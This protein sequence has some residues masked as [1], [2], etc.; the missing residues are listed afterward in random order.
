MTTINPGPRFF[1]RRKDSETGDVV[2]PGLAFVPDITKALT[3]LAQM[4]RREDWGD[5]HSVLYNYINYTVYE[6]VA[7]GKIVEAT[8]AQGRPVAAFNTG[9]LTNEV[10]PV[11]GFLTQ[12]RTEVPLAQP[13]YFTRWAV[14][15]DVAMRPFTK[16]PERARYWKESPAELL[17]NPEWPVEVRLEHIVDDNVERF[18]RL[19]Q[20]L[21][22]LRKHALRGAIHDA[23]EQIKADPHLAIPAYHF[24]TGSVSLLLPLR[25]V[26]SHRVDLALVLG[27][28]GEKRYAAWTVMPLDWAYRSARLIKAPSADW[29]DA[30]PAPAPD[31][32][33]LS[34]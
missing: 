13:W 20:K 9:L 3:D 34:A 27:P 30:T 5:N 22:H 33:Y 25:L 8:D 31:E 1:F 7:E 32:D 11:L 17:F 24:E 18:P 16:A 6:L 10:Q 23:L 21:P 29:L 12:N 14:S 2:D 26:H 15:S 28:F 4:A 19:L